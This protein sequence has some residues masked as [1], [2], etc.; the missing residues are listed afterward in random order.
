MDAV[1]LARSLADGGRVN[2][3][4]PSTNATHM[5]RVLGEESAYLLKVY[6]VESFARREERSFQTLD[7]APGTPTILERGDVEGV[8]WVKIADPGGWTFATLPENLDAARH[9]GEL[10]RNVHQHAT[11]NVTNLQGGMSGP[12]VAADFAA[13]FLRLERFR[14]RVN[15]PKETLALA[16]AVPPPRSSEPVL[17]HTNPIAENFFVDD[18]GQV[19]LL[20]WSWSTLAP[21]EWDF[22]L[23]YWSLS[24]TVSARAADAF[25]EG[26]GA[27]LSDEDLRPWIVYH[28]GSYLLR[29]AETSSGRLDHHKSKV[30]QLL[31]YATA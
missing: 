7:G 14:G 8:H 16:A 19:T 3:L 17:S 9:A 11:A 25:A 4:G 28:I 23:A 22:S 2:Q 1:Q 18:D 15:M 13:T 6:D 31:A 24:A 27:S 12:Q 30:D 5:F 10:I 20:D 29:I 26:Y 21:P